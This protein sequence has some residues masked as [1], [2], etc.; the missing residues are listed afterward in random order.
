MFVIVLNSNNIVDD[1][2]NNKLVY[3]FPN[4]LLFKNKSIA[5][6]SISMYY[7]WANISSI[8][9]NNTFSY[10]WTVGSTTTTYTIT[11][12]NGLY[13]ISDLNSLL[14]YTM[15]SNGTYLVNGTQNVY[16]AEFVVNPAR[17]AVEINTYLVPTSLPTGYTAPSNFVGYPT[18]SFNPVITLPANINQ[19]LGYSAGFAT[20]GNVGNAYVPASSYVS[21]LSSGTLSYLSTQAPTVQPNSSLYLSMSNINNPYSSPSSIIYSV[22]AQGSSGTLIT[23]RPPNFMWNKMIDGTYS[24]LRLT[25]LGYDYS[26]IPLNDKQMTIMLTIKDNDEPVGK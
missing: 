10:T 12:P 7:C 22:V 17:Y 1:G 20:N 24:E 14:Q 5:V 16:Y 13:E 21:K 2:Q 6:S 26:P 19:I 3:K 4:S 11:I 9:N 23:E 25:F 18:T 15:I 8:Y